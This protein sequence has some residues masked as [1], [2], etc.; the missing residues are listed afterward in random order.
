MK[1]LLIL[2]ALLVL[3]AC[4]GVVS[5]PA[6]MAP[7]EVGTVRATKEWTRTLTGGLGGPLD[8]NATTVLVEVKGAIR[9]CELDEHAAPLFEPG[10]KV[11]LTLAKRKF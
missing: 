2:P 1:K 6:C 5:E 10:M 7:T 3:S 4:G 11:S 8:I 9:V